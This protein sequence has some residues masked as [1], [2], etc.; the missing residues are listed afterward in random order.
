MYF[1]DPVTPA[2]CRIV[3]R[4]LNNTADLRVPLAPDVL[5]R[6]I[7]AASKSP[8]ESPEVEVDGVRCVRT[9]EGVRVL[10]VATNHTMD[11]PWPHIAR[12]IAVEEDA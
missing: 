6:S 4:Y 12:G 1:I 2:S 9:A 11:I 7:N 5:L 8:D 10:I 3:M